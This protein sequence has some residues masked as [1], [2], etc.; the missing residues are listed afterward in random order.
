MKAVLRLV[1]AG[2][3]SFV[4][5]A[6][7]AG[8]SGSSTGTG[9]GTNDG[10]TGT[11][12]GNATAE[13]ACTAVASWGQRCGYEVDKATCVAE[14]ASY[15]PKQFDAVTACA[16]AKS[17]DKPTF[18]ACFEKAL[19]GGGGG[20][21]TG[22]A[23]TTPQTPCGAC[24]ES[25]CAPS[26]NACNANSECVALASCASTAGTDDEI[27]DCIDQHPGGLDD[28]QAL[29]TCQQNSCSTQCE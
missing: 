9:T 4:A 18:D 21:A 13:S 12:S 3:S 11:T 14:G 29:A 5:V 23:G 19:G 17:C 24:T 6:L 10:G 8:C 27:Q 20:T 16:S 22:D 26:Y 2:V 7:V 28:I 15:G 1:V 25:K